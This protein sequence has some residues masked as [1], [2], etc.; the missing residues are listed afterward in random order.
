[1]PRSCLVEYYMA[2]FLTATLPLSV[3][4]VAHLFLSPWPP[5]SLSFPPVRQEHRNTDPAKVQEATKKT[6]GD[7]WIWCQS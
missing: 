4:A 7:V 3:S 2:F 5:L 1:M 6:G